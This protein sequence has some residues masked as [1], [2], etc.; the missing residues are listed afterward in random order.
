MK[1][2]RAPSTCHKATEEKLSRIDTLG[3]SSPKVSGS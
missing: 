3:W 2:C 1:A